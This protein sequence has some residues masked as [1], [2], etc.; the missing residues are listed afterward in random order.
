MMPF[1]IWDQIR[2]T[3][4]LVMNKMHLKMSNSNIYTKS[5][6]PGCPDCWFWW[7]FFQRRNR[8]YSTFCF[9]RVAGAFW[10][11]VKLF[12]VVF[13]WQGW[14]LQGI[15][16]TRLQAL[17]L[18]QVGV[19]PKHVGKSARTRFLFSLCTHT[20]RVH[21]CSDAGGPRRRATGKEPRT[22]GWPTDK[23]WVLLVST[24]PAA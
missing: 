7:A 19:L 13:V 20:L 9:E 3:F 14:V 12:F 8:H 17:N 24:V 6:L 18:Q 16:K 23:R 22:D 5:K 1:R 11:E 4:G 15:P 10:V 2:S 21:L